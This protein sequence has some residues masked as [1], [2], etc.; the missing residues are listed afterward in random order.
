MDKKQIFYSTPNQN[1]K[2]IRSFRTG[3]NPLSTKLPAIL[4]QEDNFRLLD[5]W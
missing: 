1:F 5:L 3:K 2:C 4:T